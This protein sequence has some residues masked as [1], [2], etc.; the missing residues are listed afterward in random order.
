LDKLKRLNQNLAQKKYRSENWYKARNTLIKWHE[1]IENKRAYFL[2]NL[3]RY[4]AKN[5]EKVTIQKWPLNK[6]IKYAIDNKTARRLCDGAYGKFIQMLKHKCN[7]SGTEF[8]E[9]KELS[10]QTEIERLTEQAKMEELTRVLRESKKAVNRKYHARFK[11]LETA[12]ERLMMLR[13]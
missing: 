1:R 4:Y 2:W 7:E 9:R 12:C 13:I 8:I 5:F 10:W 6:E 11:Y 3:A